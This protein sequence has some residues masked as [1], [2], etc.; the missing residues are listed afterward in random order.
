MALPEAGMPCRLER[1]WGSGGDVYRICPPNSQPRCDACGEPLPPP[2]APGRHQI[3]PVV[4][5]FSA[6]ALGAGQPIT[7]LIHEECQSPAL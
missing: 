6:G 4:L 7:H 2:H 1:D 5:T 3:H